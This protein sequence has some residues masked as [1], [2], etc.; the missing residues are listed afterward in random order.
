MVSFTALVLAVACIIGAFAIPTNAAE[1]DTEGSAP[2]PGIEIPEMSNYYLWKDSTAQVNFTNG[3]GGQYTVTWTSGSFIAGKGWN[4]GSG[5]RVI[6]YAGAYRANGNSWLGVYGWT[7]NPLVEYNIVETFGTYDPSTAAVRKGSVTCNG[8]TYNIFQ[9]TRINQPSIDG[10]KTFFQFWSVRSPKKSPGGS[11]SGTVDMACH[12]NAWRVQG[13]NLGS[14][15]WQVVAT[16]GYLGSSG[17][18]TITVA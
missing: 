17:S 10:T 6:N 11:I 2:F 1:G 16:V 14:Y 8:A 12:F 4:P 18:S 13:M 9:A 7:R 5:S 15:S 3:P